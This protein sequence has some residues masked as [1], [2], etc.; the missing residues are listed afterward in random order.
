MNFTTDQLANPLGILME[1][2]VNANPYPA[3]DF[4]RSNAPLVG[5]EMG[6]WYATS[7][8]LVDEI[9]TS[10]LT[11]TQASNVMATLPMPDDLWTQYYD[12]ELLFTD[13]ER[14]AFL[15]KFAQAAFKPRRVKKLRPQ[16]EA[17]VDRYLDAVADKGSMD[18]VGDL[19]QPFA[20]LTVMRMIGI[21]DEAIEDIDRWSVAMGALLDVMKLMDPTYRAAGIAAFSECIDYVD[22]LMV[23][24]AANPQDDVISDFVSSLDQDGGLSRKDIMGIVIRGMINAGHA[25]TTNQ[26]GN[27]ILTMTKF[28]EQQRKL[29]ENPELSANAIEEMFRFDPAIQMSPRCAAEDMTIGGI[30]VAKGQLMWALGGAANRDPSAFENPNDLDIERKIVGSLASGNGEHYC[31]GA[32]LARLETEVALTKTLERFKD[33]EVAVPVEELPRDGNMTVRGCTSIP[34]TFELRS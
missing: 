25:T 7:H 34:L 32:V 8:E 17:D 13:A 26:I 29:V 12:H 23:E 22:E 19:A 18:Y 11:T 3:Y 16:L 33:I 14:H 4:M 5:D 20:I 27:N 31:L 1:P 24:R 28:P 10:P 15:R 2:Q 30:E 6:M 21:P 9:L